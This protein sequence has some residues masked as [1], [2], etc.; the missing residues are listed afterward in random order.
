MIFYRSLAFLLLFYSFGFCFE[1]KTIPTISPTAFLKWD[2]LQGPVSVTLD[3]RGSADLNF[4]QTEQAL[5][6]ALN[7]WQNVPGQRVRFQYDGV[8]SLQSASGT[9][10]L[11]SVQWIESG[12]D[13]SSHAIAVTSYSYYLQDPPVIID[14]DIFMNGQNYKWT[15]STADSQTV[16]AQET[17][18]HE[19]G[20]LL[21]ISHT[22]VTNAQMFPYLSGTAN[23]KL[24][25]DDKAAL[26]FRYGTPNLSFAPVTPIRRARYTA[27]LSREGLPLPV[28]RWND[29][30]DS[31]YIVEFSN[32]TTFAKKI[33]VTTA[34]YPFYQLTPSMERK[35]IKLYGEDKIF[36]RVRSGVAVSASRPFRLQQ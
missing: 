26:R 36:W 23:H 35:L 32:S 21:G 31:N 16:D 19:I 20:H 12:W 2:L 24:M 27:N 8:V 3:Q 7:V 6:S 22:G 25:R 5:V 4:A 33:R 29:G 18:I 14:A 34:P 9:D 15:T 30:P 11:N 1:V 28:F 10:E 17:L 13:Y